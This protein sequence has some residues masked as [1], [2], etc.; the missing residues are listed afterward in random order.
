MIDSP[1]IELYAEPAPDW[2][3]E[4]QLASRVHQL[5]LRLRERIH[6]AGRSLRPTRI[7]VERAPAE[8][9]GLGVG[10]QLSLAVARALLTL[11]GEADMA[12][13]DLAR[14][15]ARG[16]RSG[17]G[18][19]GFEHGGLIVDGGSRN[20]AEIPP[21]LARL[22]FPPTWSVLVVQPPG[23][24]GLHGP[25]ES[26]AFANLRPIAQ[27]VTDSMCR[28]VLLEILPAVIEG[29]LDA[30]GA[31]LAE[32]QAKVG[33]CFAAAQGGIYATSGA[34]QI[35]EELSRTGFVGAGQSSWGP[36][37]YAFSSR[38]K[39]EINHA[40]E[41]IRQRTG[42]GEDDVFWTKANNLGAAITFEG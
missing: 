14:W 28:L 32:M 24:R 26:S 17:I 27:S 10:T 3:V 31:A 30:F 12:V 4:G 13:R 20:E 33:S 34:P 19:H 6:E 21:L 8:H 1:A 18:V 40:V 39:H 37:L 29:D 11:A 2:I 41:R 25:K 22:P 7:R 9:I 15:T 35:I 42:L 36:T 38:P 16:R 5:I 23:Q